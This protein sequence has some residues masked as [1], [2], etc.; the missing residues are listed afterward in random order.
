SRSAPAGA[1]REPPPS[2]RSDPRVRARDRARSSRPRA[3]PALAVAPGLERPRQAGEVGGREALRT[4]SRVDS[5]AGE[6][7]PKPRVVEAVGRGERAEGVPQRL[8]AL[9]ERGADDGAVERG[10]AQVDARRARP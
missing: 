2:P 4:R 9:S 10:I 3:A 8:S 6:R 7:R 1:P 5:G